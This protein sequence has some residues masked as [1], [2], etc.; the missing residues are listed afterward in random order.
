MIILVGLHLSQAFIWGAYK[1]PRQLTWLIG[2]GQLLLTLALGYTGPILPWD[3]RGYWEAEVGT[4]FAGTVPILG[5]IAKN[6]LSGSP[7]LGQMTV[8]RFFFLHVAI[9]PGALIILISLHLVAFRSFGISGPWSEAKRKSIGHFWPDQVFQDAL[10]I[11]SIFVILVGLAAYVRAPFAGPLDLMQTF[12]VPKPEWYFL[13]LYQ[14]LKAFPGRLEPVATVGI[15]LFV[16][17]LLVFLPFIDRSPERNPA[18]RPIVMIC[19]AIF[20]AW[21]MTMAIT[22]Y[23]S[24]PPAATAFTQKVG[25]VET[26]TVS[27]SSVSP[28]PQVFES[29]KQGAQLFDSLGC[30]GCHRINGRGGMV[31]PELSPKVLAGKTRQ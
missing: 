27:P 25:P 17:L 29:A 5:T 1:N 26:Q 30:I 12:Y 11:T 28:S 24:K 16:V 15:P 18:R 6:L 3:E 21:V 8:S 22:G 20:V 23:Y 2:V 13:F 19:Y 14:T 9:L 31:G 4:G 7:S 10:M